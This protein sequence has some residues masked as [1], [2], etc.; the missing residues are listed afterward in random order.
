[1]A[2]GKT[3]FFFFVVVVLAILFDDRQ[4]IEPT[5][6]F[7]LVQSTFRKTPGGVGIKKYNT[8]CE[9]FFIYLFISDIYKCP[10]TRAELQGKTRFVGYDLVFFGTEIAVGPWARR[11]FAVCY[12]SGIVPFLGLLNTNVY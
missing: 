8:R 11:K 1:M 2:L 7:H 4:N 9:H 3:T 5:T 10:G 6:D 12:C